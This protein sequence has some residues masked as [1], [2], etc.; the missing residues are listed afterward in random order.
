[1][2][3]LQHTVVDGFAVEHVQASLIDEQ[4]HVVLTQILIGKLQSLQRPARNSHVEGFPCTH[5]VDQCLQRLVERC[6]RV[7]AMTIEEVYVVDVQASERLV[8]RC[9]E[10]LAR[11]PVAIGSRPHVVAG[12]RGDEQ[13]IAEGAEVV[14]HQS[15]EGLFGG[16]IGRT[17]VVCQV[18]VGDTMIEGIVCDLTTALIGVDASEVVPESQRHLRQQ[19]T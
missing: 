5:D 10:I 2:T 18:E 3:I 4:R 17:V 14:V 9:H 19:N 1:M 7:V 11:A 6:L 16:P 15:A 8:E 13:F 12:L